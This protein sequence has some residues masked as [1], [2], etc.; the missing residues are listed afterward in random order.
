MTWW[1]VAGFTELGELGRGAQGRVVL[2]QHGASGLIVA[3]K[4]VFSLESIERFRAEAGLLR[5][6]VDPHVARLYDYV[7]RPGEGAAMVMEAVDGVSLKVALSERGPLEPMAAL[8]VLK[9]SLLGLAAAHRVGIVHR[10]YKPANVVVQA[11]GHSKL[12]DFGIAT[13]AGTSAR[14]GTPAYMAPEQ[15]H[16]APASPATDVYAATG[17]FFE[18]VTGQSPSARPLPI[19]RVPE[20]LQ[21]LVRR[22]LSDSPTARPVGAAEFVI[23]LEAAAS[24][25]Y[26]DG[27]EDRGVVLLAGLAAGLAALFPVAALTLPA[28]G[29]AVGN[30]LG[31]AAR[32]TLKAGGRAPGHGVRG[33]VGKAAATKPAL[34]VAGSAVIAGGAIVAVIVTQG[35]GHPRPPVT[36]APVQVQ[37]AALNENFTT[38]VIHVQNAQYAEVSGL[39]DQAAQAKINKALRAP[40]NSAIDDMQRLNKSLTGANPPGLIKATTR[41]G[42]QSPVLLS[43]A[44][45]VEGTGINAAGGTFVFETAFNFDLRTGRQLGSADI[46][47]ASTLTTPGMATLKSRL[48]VTSPAFCTSLP[49]TLSDFLPYPSSGYVRDTAFFTKDTTELLVNWGGSS[50]APLCTDVPRM[51]LTAPL[52]RI[53][54]LLKPQ[55][56]NDLEGVGRSPSA[57]PS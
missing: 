16:G 2:A 20:D 47:A 29:G 5:Q 43:V 9:G 37:V 8:V 19:E 53:R 50:A 57:T 6:V 54:D 14:S 26:G 4:Y 17:V 46:W 45:S 3:I 32:T 48:A 31:G 7:E 34:A 15:W 18:C 23:E 27:W 13:A 42:I 44:T 33:A 28:G 52:E 1:R 11:T 38:P 10:D 24:A 35:S 12:I 21:E 25:T 55:F 51:I 41:I 36:P 49:V 56:A 22:G 30:V 39:R 40:L